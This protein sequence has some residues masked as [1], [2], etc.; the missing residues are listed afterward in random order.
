MLILV[1][2]FL[3][4]ISAAWAILIRLV[5]P[6][7]RFG[8]LITA[9][10]ATLAWISVWLWRLNLPLLLQLPPWQPEALFVDSPVF[11][12]DEIAWAYGLGLST[13]AVASLLTAVA[14]AGFPQLLAWAGTLGLT[15]LGMLAVLANNPLTLA[16]VWVSL[17]LAELL[18]Q[19]R[20]VNGAELNRRAVV[21]FATRTGGTGILLW[22]NSVSL[23]GGTHLNFEAIPLQV[24]VY[25]LIAAGLRLGILPLHLPFSAE[26]GL[27]RGF[28]TSIRLVTAAA[29]LIILARI[30]AGSISPALAPLL[31]T[32]VALAGLYGGWMWL[33]ANNDLNGRP[34]WLLGMASLSAIS[35]LHGN[36]IGSAAWGIALVLS[37]TALFLSSLE[38]PILKRLLLIGS[39]GI[40]AM[41]LSVTAI[42]WQGSIAI[43]WFFWPFLV[44]IHVLLIAGYIR[45]TMRPA[46][47]SLQRWPIWAQNLYPAGILLPLIVLVVL[48]FWGWPGALRIGVWPAALSVMI[49]TGVTVW[50]WPRLKIAPARVHWVKLAGIPWLD[51]FYQALGGLYNAVGALT[52]SFS[53]LLEGDGG[54]LWML[55]FLIIFISLLTS[56]AMAP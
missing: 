31:T 44:A 1:S 10:G 37:G 19:I 39:W 25:L 49:L 54:I 35:A 34:F 8:W 47:F 24:G 13:L 12:A 33:R 29:S 42:A 17:D 41:P 7:F 14:R 27:R 40:S 11:L 21:A 28:G 18:I 51:W 20:S 50:T 23:A 5:K 32:L 22:A 16:L 46:K 45:H 36:P 43:G 3:F 2:F 56:G 4:V 52:R 48:G 9:L 6:E 55:L 15:A 26:S 38:H 53:S 30:P